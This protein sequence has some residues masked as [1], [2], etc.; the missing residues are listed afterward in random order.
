[1]SPKYKSMVRSRSNTAGALL[2]YSCWLVGVVCMLALN[3][4]CAS[5]TE[6]STKA[7]QSRRSVDEKTVSFLIQSQQALQQGALRAAQVLADSVVAR[8]PR[9][10]DAHFQRARVLS[11]L[12]QFDRAEEAYREVLALDP[13]YRGVWYNLGNNAYR[14]QDYQQ[15]VTFYRK[16]QGQHPSAEA[17]VS[18]GWTYVAQ[19]KTDSARLAYEKALSV[20]SSYALAYARLGQWYEDQGELE[21]ALKYSRRALELQPNNG[22]YQYVVGSQLLRL[23][24]PEVAVEHLKQAT[25]ARPWHQGAHFSLGQALMRLGREQEAERYLAGADS[26]EQLQ[27]DIKRLQ[28]I[29]RN[30]PEN[31]KSWKKLGEK[32][33]EAGQVEEAQKAFSMALY[34]APED[35][36]L[37]NNIAM[38]SAELGNSKAAV[39]HFQALLTQHPSFVEGW[40]NLGVVYARSGNIQQAQ[41]AWKE[42]LRRQPDHQRAKAYLARSSSDES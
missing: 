31:S 1:M 9:L 6:E 8:A 26:L 39:R 11:E 19:S 18:L 32:L 21:T 29:A 40:F 41:Q 12:K 35:P 33:R 10:P 15:A 2:L 24:Q 17:L 23:D 7:A 16:A 27:S 14:Q 38:L 13:D 28:S 3:V 25:E 30:N 22:K 20:D 34:L 5:D 42:V 4:R 36:I 37:R